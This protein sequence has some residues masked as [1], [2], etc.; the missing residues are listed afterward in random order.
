MYG[1]IE[2]IHNF[3]KKHYIA[4]FSTS[5]IFKKIGKDNFEKKLKNK[6]KRRSQF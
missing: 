4:K 2:A 3:F 5:S 1:N 6:I